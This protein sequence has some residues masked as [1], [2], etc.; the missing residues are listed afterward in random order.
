MAHEAL[1][2]STSFVLP[3]MIVEPAD[4]RRMTRELE[5][6]DEFLRQAK[7]R[8]PGT[9]VS[10]PKTTK[11]LDTFVEMNALQLLDAVDR[12]KAAE[13]L[14]K[15][16]S[17]APVVHISFATD[18]SAVFMTKIITWLRQNIH[19]LLLVQIG[20]Q[21]SIAAGCVVRTESKVF[22]FSLRQYLVARRDMLTQAITGMNIAQ[23]QPV[24]A[25][26][27]KPEVKP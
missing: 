5:A 23:K 25:P 14:E 3:V 2:P 22:D 12:A 7:I 9:P 8:K 21:P 18:P 15:V 27:E 19:P 24:V 17:D 16:A 4:V 6:V 11:N 1:K 20:L 10:V 26:V 13:F